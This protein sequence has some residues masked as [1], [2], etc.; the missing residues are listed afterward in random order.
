M[1][2]KEKRGEQRE[3]GEATRGQGIFEEAASR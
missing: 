1:S 2:F 3:A